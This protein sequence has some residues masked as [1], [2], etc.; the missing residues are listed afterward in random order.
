MTRLPDATRSQTFVIRLQRDRQTF[1]GQVVAVATGETHLFEDLADAMAFI[2]ARVGE[3]QG[4]TGRPA[5]ATPTGTGSE[6]GT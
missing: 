4:E 6:H 2:Q 3:G 1:R 5:A